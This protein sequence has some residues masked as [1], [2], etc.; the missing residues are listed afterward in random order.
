MGLRD[1]F[2]TGC[3]GGCKLAVKI[4]S[5]GPGITNPVLLRRDSLILVDWRVLSRLKTVLVSVQ[6]VKASSSG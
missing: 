1:S 5:S 2:G 4:R 6:K 3:H